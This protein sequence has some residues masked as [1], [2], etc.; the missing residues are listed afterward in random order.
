[1]QGFD[2]HMRSTIRAHLY[3][4]YVDDIIVVMPPASD[5]KTLRAEISQALPAGLQLNTRKSRIITFSANKKP[6]PSIEGDF[7][8]L[9]FRFSV[10]ETNKKPEPHAR[11]VILDISQSKVKNRKTRMVRSIL[12]YKH[13]G[14]FDDLRDRFKL[15]TCNYRFYDHQKSKFRLA[16]TRHTYGLINRPSDA[17]KQLDDFQRQLILRTTGKLGTHLA[18]TLT[19]K[20][21]RELLRLS[22]TKGYENNVHFHFPPDR[23][24]N[25]MECWK[26]A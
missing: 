4:R 8:Y 12:Q 5:I 16:G 7:D 13:D 3:A 11:Q 21:R 24:N 1:M 25:L 2:E 19:R 20:Q 6:T 18:T 17:L 9:G 26:Y 22:S 10:F 14:N 15:I 23:L